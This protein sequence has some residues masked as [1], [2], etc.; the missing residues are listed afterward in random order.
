MTFHAGA[1]GGALPVEEL[2]VESDTVSVRTRIEG[3]AVSLQLAL[4][5]ALLVG[6][7]R[8]T[9]GDHVLAEG[10]A[11]LAR[12]S[13]ASA[14]E[15][16]T[17][18]LDAQGSP[19]DA[20][21]RGFVIERAAELMLANYAFADRAQQ[22]AAAVR[23]RATRGEY[24]SLASPR[25]GRAVEPAPRRSDLRSSRPCEV[26]S[27]AGSRSPGRRRRDEGGSR[28]SSSRGGGRELRRR[29]S[30]RSTGTSVTSN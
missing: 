23:A 6:S 14:T 19:I 29:R 16:L 22:A 10:P 26:R 17:R 4:D 18:W 9:E 27:G 13:D 25:T 8:V 12:A 21:R 5:D 30:P 2:R 24:D 7:V 20:G 11:G 28:A 3:A 15:R 1:D